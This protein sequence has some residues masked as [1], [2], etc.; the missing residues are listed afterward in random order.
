M[1]AL[2]VVTFNDT[3]KWTHTRIPS[4]LQN[5]VLVRIEACGLN[6]ADLLL[7]QGI[8][9]ETPKV[10]FTLGMELA[11]QIIS[12]G[13][14]VKHL[15]AGQ[16]VAIY[17]G[18]GGLAEYGAFDADR[19]IPIPNGLSITDAAGVQIAYG[20]S[21]L[22]L[23]YKGHMQKDETLVV[24]GA[25]GGVGLTAVEIGKTMGGRVI[26]LARGRSKLKEAARAGADFLIDSESDHLTDQVKE[27]GGADI[28]YDPVGGNLFDDMFRACKPDG[29]ILVVGF[30]SGKLPVI[31]ANHMMVKNLSIIGLNWGGYLRFKPKPLRESL[32]KLMALWADGKLRPH[33]SHILPFERAL[34][35]LELVKSRKS[36]GKVVIKIT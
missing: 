20:T 34:D 16:K 17:S 14:M 19:C 7:N 32:Q 3:P 36:T 8:Y 25:A 26:A 23:S 4:P 9:Q 5:Q 21:H 15:K 28:V 6:F 1:K 18:Q 35:G 13:A 22:A 24:L 29:R 11:G 12:I 10:P 2:Q 27:L 33:V 30:A 31:K